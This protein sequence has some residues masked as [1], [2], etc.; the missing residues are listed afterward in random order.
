MRKN[1]RTTRPNK[2]ELDATKVPSTL[3]IAFAAGFYE[4]EGTC[5][6]SGHNK[7]GFMLSVTQKDPEVLHWLRDWFGGSVR[8]NGTG[9]G[10]HIWDACG[11]R[12]RIFAALIY[13]YLSGRRKVQIDATD[14]LD[15]LGG[16][17]SASLTI[18]ELKDQMLKFYEQETSMIGRRNPEILKAQR[19]ASHQRCK[20]KLLQMKATA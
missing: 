17:S 4:G 13:S 18:S 8:D 6:M 3:D 11:D 15:F 14:A 7:R 2:P 12:G 1:Y 9:C 16:K 5:R 20:L 10:V 19:A